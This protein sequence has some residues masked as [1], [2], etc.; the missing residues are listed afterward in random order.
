MT[1][2][3]SAGSQATVL[4]RSADDSTAGSGVVADPPPYR[5]LEPDRGAAVDALKR[6]GLRMTD[7]ACEAVPA[8]V[9]K[10]WPMRPKGW[11][12]PTLVHPDS[13]EMSVALAQMALSTSYPVAGDFIETGVFTGG[14]SPWLTRSSA[15]LTRHCI[16]VHSSHGGVCALCVCCRHVHCDDAR[17]LRGRSRQATLLVRA[18]PSMGHH[19]LEHGTAGV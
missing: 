15:H 19:L 3:A 18:P 4:R 1:S 2:F 9:A 6:L 12:L 8:G 16:S 10:P 14:M 17:P 11:W 7:V 13:V 5:V